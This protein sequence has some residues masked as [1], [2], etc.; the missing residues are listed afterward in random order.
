MS[1]NNDPSR[2]RVYQLALQFAAQIDRLIST[3]RCSSS[4]ADQAKR[5]ASSIV[6]N[7]REAAYY[8]SPG[9]KARFF[10]IARGS[11]GEALG[12]LDLY[13]KSNPGIDLRPERTNAR[14]L[15]KMLAVLIQTNRDRR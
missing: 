15:A 9:Q 12:F 1:T 2:L 10:D 13:E 11:V 7:I 4:L 6:L 5:Q 8:T 3:G 14:M